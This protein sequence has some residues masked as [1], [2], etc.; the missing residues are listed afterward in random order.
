MHNSE[1][2]PFQDIDEDV[3]MSSLISGTMG[4]LDQCSV[5]EYMYVN[6]NNSLSV[7]V[8]MDDEQWDKNV[9]RG[10]GACYWK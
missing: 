1:K 7:C 8:D 2:D 4:T 5:E 3:D 10:S 6:G 9:L